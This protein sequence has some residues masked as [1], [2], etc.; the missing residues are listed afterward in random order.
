[1]GSLTFL[2]R[3]TARPPS[4]YLTINVK[5]TSVIPKAIAYLRIT[6]LKQNTGHKVTLQK[7][8]VGHIH[9]FLKLNADL[10]STPQQKPNATFRVTFL[11]KI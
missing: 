3:N 1:M 6:F 8:N 5:F 2:T 4:I 10:K 11:N 7:P 9:T